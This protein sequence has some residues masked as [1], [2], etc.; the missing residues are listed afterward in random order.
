MDFFLA[1]C[2]AKEQ[3]TVQLRLVDG[4]VVDGVVESQRVK[5]KSPKSREISEWLDCLSPVV[6]LPEESSMQSHCK[7]ERE[8]AKQKRAKF[9]IRTS[10]LK[11]KCFKR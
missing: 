11:S 5:F 3:N 8:R 7:R 2:D 9:F 1:I 10:N 6:L 4:V